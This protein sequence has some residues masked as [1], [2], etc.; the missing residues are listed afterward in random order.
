MLNQIFA[1][2][3]KDLKIFF[4]DPGAVVLIFLQPFM[5]IVVMSYAL[6]GLFKSGE[7]QIHLLVVNQDR[8]AQAAAI[9]QQLD[10][11][12]AFHLET[13]WN[14]QPVTRE[15]AEEL[16]ITEQRNLA[17]VFPADFSEVLEQGPGTVERLT[18]QV[19]LIVDPATPSQ[20]VEPILGTLQGLIERRVFM[21]MVPKGVDFLYEQLAPQMPAEQREAFKDQAQAAMSGG[22]LG[23]ENPIVTIDRSAPPGMRIEKYPDSFQQNVPGYT[24]YGLFWIVIS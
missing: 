3:W 16:I 1:L 10:E 7:R 12:D 17:L 14:G 18:T 8:G 23:E 6:G 22:F 20:V 19:L 13:T 24:I 11:M 4:K 15:L 5:F 2:A 21:A 9:I